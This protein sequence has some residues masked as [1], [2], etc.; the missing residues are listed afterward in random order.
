MTLPRAAALLVVFALIAL[1]VVYLRGEQA[2]TAARIHE[3]AMTQKRL[4]QASWELQMEIARLK[5]PEQIRERVER[6]QLN[7][8]APCPEP[9]WRIDTGLADVN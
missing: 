1:G 6:W 4:C 7:V 5:T 2:R 9:G 3:L 8:M